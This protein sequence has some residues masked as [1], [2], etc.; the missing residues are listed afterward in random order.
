MRAAFGWLLLAAVAWAQPEPRLPPCPEGP[1][2]DTL[3]IAPEDFLAFRPLG[4]VSLPVH[5]FP[6]KHSSFSF[7]PP[8]EPA[9]ERTVRFPG[10]VWVTQ[11]TST[12]FPAGNSGY[13]VVF[14]ACRE[15]RAYLYHLKDI[16]E[17]VKAAFEG[18]SPRCYDYVD[19]TGTIV[20][21]EG[22]VFVEAQGGE[23]DLRV[24]P[25]GFVNLQHYPFD[26]P[27]YV[28]PVDYYPPELRERFAAKLASFDGAAPRTAEPRVGSY[29]PDIAGT[30]QGN[31]FFPGVYA[32]DATDWS[33][34]VALVHDY[35]DPA[36]PVFSIGTKVE[37][38]RMGLYT[39]EPR[40]SGRVNRDFAAVRGD[41]I[42]CYEGMRGGRTAGMLPAG[43]LD[44]VLLVALE[45]DA[46]LKMERREAASCD[47][48]A[49]WT[50]TAAATLFER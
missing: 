15:F 40:E 11:V 5:I 8:G 36:Q 34:S 41:G 18:G 9:P 49:P 10:R 29:R 35:I 38:V 1:L 22:R 2:F 33:P 20:K 6:A 24:A 48:A 43:R 13:Q 47:A 42:Y 14:Y 46:G 26:Y 16:N 12:R 7:G 32:R 3:P 28:S 39:F 45:G 50:F 4:F 44:G 19:Q 25:D 31:W 37:G 21:C 30:A 27:Y 23:N 17:R